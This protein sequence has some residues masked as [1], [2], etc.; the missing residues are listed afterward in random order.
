MTLEGQSLLVY[1]MDGDGTFVLFVVM[2]IVV[3]MRMVGAVVGT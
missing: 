3:A 2:V 1:I